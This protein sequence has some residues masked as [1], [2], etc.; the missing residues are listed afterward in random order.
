MINK[1]AYESIVCITN[2]NSPK[3]KR[4]KKSFI[5]LLFLPVEF[6]HND[7]RAFSSRMLNAINANFQHLKSKKPT[8]S[9]M[10]YAIKFA[11]LLQCTFIFLEHIVARLYSILLIYSFSLQLFVFLSP[12]SLSFLISLGISLSPT[13]LSFR[14]QLIGGWIGGG[15][16]WFCGE[17]V[18]VDGYGL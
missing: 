1:E 8:P 16:V 13:S 12:T 18:V 11:I 10:V 2:Q 6:S 15:W 3:K 4:K 9:N 14:R 5:L 17:L 7:V